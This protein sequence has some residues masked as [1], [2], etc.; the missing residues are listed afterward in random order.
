MQTDVE[1]FIKDVATQTSGFMPRDLHA[2][3][4]DAGANL[5]A[6][7]NSQTNK[8]ENETLES[9]L[10]S[11]VLTDRSSEE[12]PLIMK[13]ED[14]SSSM[15]RSKKRNASALGAPKVN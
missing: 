6:R 12:K 15:D 2:L 10:R 14:F 5:L 9:R 11:Q 4:A 8:D 7:V 1:D 3:V 13:K